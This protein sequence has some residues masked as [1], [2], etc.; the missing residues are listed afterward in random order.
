MGAVGQNDAVVLIML[1]GHMLSLVIACVI[2]A[3]IISRRHARSQEEQAARNVSNLPSQIIFPQRPACWLAIRAASPEGV[4]AALGLGRS[5]PCSWSEGMT[6][7]HEFFISPRVN[8]W[9]I[10]TGLAIPTPDDDVD[11]CFR[12]LVSLSRKLGHVQFFQ[13]EKFLHYHAWARLDYGCVTRAYAWAG[14]TVWNQGG[15]TVPETELGVKCLS[16]G[17]PCPPNVA[18]MNTDKVSQLAARWNFDPASV[19]ERSLNLALGM[20][21]ELPRIY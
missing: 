20:A 3:G 14:E 8:G 6:G 5:T 11:E 1:V 2:C 10:V 12:F 15:K 4:L 13:A 18:R 21:G 7:E 17:D 16:Y 9:V 19:D